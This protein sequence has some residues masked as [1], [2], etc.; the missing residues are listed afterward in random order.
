M[1]RYNGNGNI[2]CF[3]R[4]TDKGGEE[5]VVQEKL[6]SLRIAQGLT[7][8]QMS[9]V[10]GLKTKAAYTKKELGYNSITVEEGKLLADRLGVSVDD[11]FCANELS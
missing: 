2:P 8:D 4:E 3:P 11:L 1:G 10:L 5:K 9:R 7:Q 6:R